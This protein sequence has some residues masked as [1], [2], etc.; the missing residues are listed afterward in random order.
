MLFSTT[1][2]FPIINDGQFSSSFMLNMLIIDHY[3]LWWWNQL[4]KNWIVKLMLRKINRHTSFQLYHP[5]CPTHIMLVS[6]RLMQQVTFLRQQIRCK[7]L[8]L[9][10]FLQVSYYK[11][12]LHMLSN[13]YVPSLVLSDQLFFLLINSTHLDSYLLNP[14]KTINGGYTDFFYLLNFL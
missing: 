8:P 9:E 11:N 6:S 7:Y 14:K 13:Y 3:D 12:C 2:D 4:T 5:S 10:S 1:L